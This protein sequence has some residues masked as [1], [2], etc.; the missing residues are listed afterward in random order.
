MFHGLNG[1]RHLLV[2]GSGLAS[3][4]FGTTQVIS[5]KSGVWIDG[6]SAIK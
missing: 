3:F 2:I 5:V 1:S 4:G 6:Y